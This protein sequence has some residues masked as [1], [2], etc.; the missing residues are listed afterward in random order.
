M[1]KL[2]GLSKASYEKYEGETPDKK[3]RKIPLIVL[4]NFCEL[5]GCSMDVLTRPQLRKR[6]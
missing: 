5:S 6:A 2:L 3:L 4:I 1:G